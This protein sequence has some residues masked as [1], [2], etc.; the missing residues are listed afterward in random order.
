MVI[1]QVVGYKKSG[2]TTVI[3]QLIG[4][5]KQLGLQIAVIKHHGD[6]SGNEIDIPLERDHLTYMAGGADESIIQGY[7]YIHKLMTSREQTLDDLIKEVS[8][9]PDLILVEGYK[10]ADYPKIVLLRN[11]SDKELSGLKH[12]IKIIH[13]ADLTHIN[14]TEI[15]QGLINDETI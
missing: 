8:T 1:L 3:N 11:E 9:D 6:N 5:A 14:Y 10:R 12:I 7:Q 4:A 2:K 15:I 13:T